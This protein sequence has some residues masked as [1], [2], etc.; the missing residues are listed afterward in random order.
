MEHKFVLT[1]PTPQ[2]TVQNTAASTRSLA[3][4]ATRHLVSC[5]RDKRP[6][7][8]ET[9]DLEEEYPGDFTEVERN[10]GRIYRDLVVNTTL[11]CYRQIDI[12]Y[13]LAA[14]WVYFVL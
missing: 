1:D 11:E 10:Q 8:L 6:C 4:A 7:T 9:L 12:E 3:A 14:R 5:I 2:I 13:N